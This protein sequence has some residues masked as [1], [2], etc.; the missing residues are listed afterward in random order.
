MRLLIIFFIYLV[1]LFSCPTFYD[2]VSIWLNRTNIIIKKIPQEFLNN[3]AKKYGFKIIDFNNN[4]KQITF[5]T[6]I[7]KRWCYN[8]SER[9]CYYMKREK[10]KDG[11]KYT[12]LDL[13]KNNYLEGL[14][15]NDLKSI[16]MLSKGG[17]VIFFAKCRTNKWASVY[18]NSRITKDKNGCIKVELL[19]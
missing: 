1:P 8:S 10:F 12:L 4:L 2:R 16:I 19:R 6:Y 7:K 3:E 18:N 11:I 9:E 14:T 15:K 13:I 17:R 5:V